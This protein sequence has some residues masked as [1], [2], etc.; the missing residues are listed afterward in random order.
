MLTLYR[1]LE[2]YTR[3][4][5]AN[6]NLFDVAVYER[7]FTPVSSEAAMHQPLSPAIRIVVNGISESSLKNQPLKKFE[8]L[9]KVFERGFQKAYSAELATAAVR[10][11]WYRFYYPKKF[12]KACQRAGFIIEKNGD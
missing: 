9:R 12:D 4:L 3:T 10:L 6:V 5:A 11:S 8:S 2:E 1:H 7:L